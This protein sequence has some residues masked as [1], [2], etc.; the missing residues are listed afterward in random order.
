MG[1]L[2]QGGFIKE[3]RTTQIF[4]VVLVNST[5]GKLPKIYGFLN[6]SGDREWEYWL[7]IS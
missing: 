4:R 3:E 7:K 1:T 5:P 2:A 6:L